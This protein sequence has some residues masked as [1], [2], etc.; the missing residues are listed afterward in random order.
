MQRDVLQPTLNQLFFGM[1]QFKQELEAIKKPWSIQLC[2]FV[3]KQLTSEKNNLKFSQLAMQLTLI[4][5]TAKDEA[6]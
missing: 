1:Q 5:R 6:I 4:E 2:Y 3:T